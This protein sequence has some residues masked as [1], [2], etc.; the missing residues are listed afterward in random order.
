VKGKPAFYSGRVLGA[1]GTPLENALLD[2]WSGDGEGN[3]DMQIP[4]AEL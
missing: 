1:D 4:A 3:Y 2:I